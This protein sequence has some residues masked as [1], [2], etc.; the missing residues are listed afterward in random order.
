MISAIMLSSSQLGTS[1]SPDTLP[2]VLLPG[3]RH[4]AARWLLHADVC[5]EPQAAAALTKPDH[6][7]PRTIRARTDQTTDPVPEGKKIDAAPTCA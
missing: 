2:T 5:C 7:L 1:V 6:N 3:R 4:S